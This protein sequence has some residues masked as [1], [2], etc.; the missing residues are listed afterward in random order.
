MTARRMI[1]V[2]SV[3]L[4]AGLAMISAIGATV[5]AQPQPKTAPTT[6]K[7]APKGKKAPLA[8]A[9]DSG[10]AGAASGSAAGSASTGAAGAGSAGAGEGSAVQMTEDPPPSDMSGTAENPDAPRSMLD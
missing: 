1:S 6:K 7:K 2:V 4:C 3:G 9:K 8:P 10:A 5:D